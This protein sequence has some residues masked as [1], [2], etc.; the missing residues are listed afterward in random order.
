MRI[1][2]N[3]TPRTSVIIMANTEPKIE[4]IDNVFKYLLSHCRYV[5]IEITHVIA[6]YNV[7]G[8]WLTT[9]PI[10]EI[11]RI[12]YSYAPK[13]PAA[14]PPNTIDSLTILS[15]IICQG[16]MNIYRIDT[17]MVRGIL[18]CSPLKIQ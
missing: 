18:N 15:E 5:A 12:A 16:T 4:I 10:L 13:I 14:T 11:S 1:I 3:H 9:P 8:I 6:T 7:K 17:S 2:D